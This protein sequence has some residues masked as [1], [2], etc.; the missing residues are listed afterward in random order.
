MLRKCAFAALAVML[1]ACKNGIPQPPAALPDTCSQDNECSANFRCDHEMRRCVCTSDAAC[2][3]N[4]FCNAF[5]GKCTTAVAGCSTVPGAGTVQCGAGQYC[6]TVLRTC[7]PITPYCGACKSDAECG[8][9][10]A[11]VTH[12]DFPAAGTFCVS[13]CDSSNSCANGLTCKKAS[14]GQSLCFPGAACGNSNACI[15]DSLKPCSADADCGDPQQSCDLSLKECIAANRNCPAGDA[16]DPQSKLCVQAC[17]SDNDCLTLIEHAPGYQ[18]RAN[19][20]FRLNLCSTDAECSTGQICEPNPDGSKSCRNGCG[21]NSD[22]PLGESCNLDPSHP[23]CQPSCT[24]NVDCAL[25]TVCSGGACV[26]TTAACSTQTCQ[27]TSVCPIGSTCINNCCVASNLATIC[28]PGGSGQVCG[29]CPAGGCTDSASNCAANCLLV[30]LS[31]CTVPAD[32]AGKGYP[33]NVVCS[34]VFNK[35]EVLIHV[36]SCSSDADCPMK[37]FKCLQGS[38][39]PCGTSV[40]YPIEVSAGVACAEG[41][42]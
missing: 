41:H 2:P 32:C 34:T 30:N 11:C 26:S 5:T 24:Q 16:C 22:C 42:P 35:C 25:N 1:A 39:N 18:C 27:D 20:C 29:S 3:N 9:G 15:P 6:N 13:A 12:P 28:P 37:G 14:N 36:Q 17:A 7:K 10:S 23:S 21:Q 19:A 8:A 38:L 4:Q 33:A 31:A 40:C